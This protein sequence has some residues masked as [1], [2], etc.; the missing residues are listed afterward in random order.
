MIRKA[1]VAEPENGAYL[2]SLGWVLFKREKYDEALPYLEK[3][4]KNSP[5]AGDET[6][7]EHLA[8]VY[9]R[10]KQPAKAVEHWKKALDF[11]D[12]AP[13]PDKKLIERVKEKI[14]SHE[15]NAAK[16]KPN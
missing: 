11:A 8:D 16:E 7:W 5:G 14:A 2:D 15:K 4:V 12:K 13:F 1:L 9:E 3:A 6:L 10:L